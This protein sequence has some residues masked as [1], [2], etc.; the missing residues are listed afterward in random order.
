L[1]LK[2]LFFKS[3]T[4]SPFELKSICKAKNNPYHTNVKELTQESS[5]E[6]MNEKMFFCV[7]SLFK[8]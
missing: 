3:K 7:F 6:S 5:K 2:K 8:I 1:K 4:T